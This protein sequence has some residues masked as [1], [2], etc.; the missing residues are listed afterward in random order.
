MLE[1]AERE[2]EA[3]EEELAAAGGAGGA[4]E[5]VRLPRERDGGRVWSV[6]GR[7]AGVGVGGWMRGG[8]GEEG[9]AERGRVWRERWRGAVGR[10]VGRGRR[11]VCEW[12][13]LLCDP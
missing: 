5:E 2:R 4:E 12:T 9:E 10:G 11:V 13:G 1:R 8:E 6:D 3:R 7:G